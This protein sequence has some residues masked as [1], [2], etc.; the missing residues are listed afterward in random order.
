MMKWSAVD[1]VV[2]FMLFSGILCELDMFLL[3]IHLLINIP[4]LD[5]IY[6]TVKDL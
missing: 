4:A 1:C 6:V 2:E 5:E 3:K